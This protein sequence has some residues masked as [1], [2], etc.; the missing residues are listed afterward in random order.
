MSA[1]SM[2]L[3]SSFLLEPGI[4]FHPVAK[5]HIAVTQHEP[6]CYVNLRYL[7]PPELF[8]DPYELANYRTHYQFQYNGSKNLELPVYALESSEPG[9]LLLTLTEEAEGERK[10]FIEINVP[11]HLRYVEPLHESEN[12]THRTVRLSPPEAFL[13]CGGYSNLGM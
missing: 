11:L 3:T 12:I 5:T 9:E 1:R 13:S 6:S 7:L 8:I 10:D 4:G 2:N